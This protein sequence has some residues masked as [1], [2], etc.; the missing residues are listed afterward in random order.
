MKISVIIVTRNRAD[1][2]K[3]CLNSLVRQTKK[4]DEVIIVDN[5]SFDGTSNAVV[6]FSNLL[7]IKYIF[8]PRIG[9]PIARNTGLKKAKYDIIAFID[10]DCIAKEDWIENIISIHMQEKSITC[11]QGKTICTLKNRYAQTLYLIR[12]LS[13]HKFNKHASIDTNNCSFKRKNIKN[14]FFDESFSLYSSGEDEDFG[15]QL[16]NKGMKIKYKK[17]IIVK[18]KYRNNLFSFLLQQYNYGKSTY[19][20]KMKWNI[21]NF[22]NIDSIMGFATLISRLL[23]SPI[24]NIIIMNNIR[25]IFNFYLQR[26]A[27]TVGIISYRILKIFD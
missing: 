21:K 6:N 16:I 15:L 10:D 4:S 1:E 17:G 27:Y 5:N 14:I 3:K 26:I 11:I 8:E 18:H 2:L 20:L 23:F 22:D 12:S 7:P 13:I 25:L 19:H 24:Y 9:I